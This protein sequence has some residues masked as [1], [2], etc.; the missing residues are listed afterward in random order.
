[1]DSDTRPVADPHEI[2]GDSGALTLLPGFAPRQGQIEM[3]EAVAAAL[4]EGQTLIAEAGTGIGKTFAYLAP[5]LLSGG[6]VIVSTG[7]KHLQDQ[8]FKK[9]LPAL[10][11]GL[12]LRIN[13]VL[14]K[15]RANYLC[16]YRLEKALQESRERDHQDFRRL[17]N[18][19]DWRRFTASGDRVEF[20]G[21]AEDHRLWGRV[22]STADNCLGQECPQHADCFVVKARRAAQGADLLVINHYL[23]CA[24]LALKETGF[25]ELLPVADGVI[26]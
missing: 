18:L 3:A 17:R 10:L 12:N 11:K 1:M 14:L 22:T 21:M 26:L 8:L 7:T 16:L 25:G 19:D 20:S 15:G 6:K 4:E 2:L 23:F 9:D 24:D 5:A 13:A